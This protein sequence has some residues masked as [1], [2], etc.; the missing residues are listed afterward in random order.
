MVSE[1]V[2][3]KLFNRSVMVDSYRENVDSSMPPILFKHGNACMGAR[4][5]IH[6]YIYIYYIHISIDLFQVLVLEFHFFLSSFL[7]FACAYPRKL[8][9]CKDTFSLLKVNT[10]IAHACRTGITQYSLLQ[11]F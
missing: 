9:C 5:N 8:V 1:M 4:L 7:L 2:A 6:V 11:Y 10:Y 3:S